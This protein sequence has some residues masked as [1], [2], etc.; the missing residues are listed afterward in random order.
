MNWQI[1]EAKNQQKTVKLNDIY[2]YSKYNPQRDVE[3]FMSAEVDTVNKKFILVGLGLGYHLD[4]LVEHL[5]NIEVQYI[6]LDEQEKEVYLENNTKQY[7]QLPNV[8]AFKS[9]EAFNEQ[10]QIIIPQS[11]LSAIG[12]NHPLFEFI[13]DIKIRQVSYKRFKE[14]MI[15]NFSE[16]IKRF[17]PLV[18]PNLTMKKAAL[19]ASGP[20]LNKTISW[21]EKHQQEFD[22][23]CVGSALK[24]LLAHQIMPTA[25]FMTDAQPTMLKQIDTRYN[26]ILYFLSTANYQAVSE[27]PGEKQILFQK[28][29]TRAEK[30][31]EQY[32][33]PL[34]ETGGSVATT[35]FS[36]IEW[37]G[38]KELYLFGQDLGFSEMQTHAMG[39]T[40]GKEIKKYNQLLDVVANDHTII[41]TTPNLLSYKRWFDQAFSKTSM[42]IFNTS[43]RGAK[44]KNTVFFDTTLK[45]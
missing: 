17:T 23:Y 41:R 36:Y 13:E 27:H 11:F 28:G 1:E 7:L 21:L 20:S 31:A 34:F 29:F 12:Q 40:S 35:T 24:V 3:K 30:F 37:L 22:I 10:A 38:Y 25:V 4:Y 42:K 45:S 26:G 15:E 16:N 5:E 19:V 32:E 39:S 43:E 8:H 6:L 18:K 33:Q 44:L 9:D 2:L 14:Q